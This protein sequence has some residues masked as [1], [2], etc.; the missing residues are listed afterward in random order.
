MNQKINKRNYFSNFN[1]YSKPKAYIIIPLQATDENSECGNASN[2]EDGNASSSCD[3]NAQRRREGEQQRPRHK[4]A[5][6][7]TRG[8]KASSGNVNEGTTRVRDYNSYK[9]LGKWGARSTVAA[10]KGRKK[11]PIP[12]EV[13][14]TN[15]NGRW[16]R[17]H[18]AGDGTTVL[19]AAGRH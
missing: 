12:G 17:Y 15:G 18:G 9:R 3:R 10:T 14:T 19:L 1:Q 5:I 8:F 6:N 2:S 13:R 7:S 11:P 4:E 16:R